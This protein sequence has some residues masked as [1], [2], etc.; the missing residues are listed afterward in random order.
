MLMPFSELCLS[1]VEL[2]TNAGVDT[3]SYTRLASYLST[4]TLAVARKIL[5]SSRGLSNNS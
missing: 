3:V 2:V 4:T 1:L 5:S